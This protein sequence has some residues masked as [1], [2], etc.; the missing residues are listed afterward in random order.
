MLIMN[1][2]G[3]IPVL[4]LFTAAAD[5]VGAGR[6]CKRNRKSDARTNGM[7]L[8]VQVRL[9]QCLCSFASSDLTLG[10]TAAGDE[11]GM[12]LLKSNGYIYSRQ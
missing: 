8:P 2:L 11:H 12:S 3:A 7:L 4:L 10:L 9:R 5:E 6:H 1:T